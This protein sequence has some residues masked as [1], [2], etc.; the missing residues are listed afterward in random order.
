MSQINYEK[1]PTGG[2][3]QDLQQV[4]TVGNTALNDINLFGNPRYITIKPSSI[5]LSARLGGDI[6]GTGSLFLNNSLLQ[7]AADYLGTGLR[8][9]NSGFSKSGNLL[10]TPSNINPGENINW[11]FPYLN[12]NTATHIL[13]PYTDTNGNL[14]YKGF[15]INNG[16]VWGNLSFNGTQGQLELVSA[17]AVSTVVTSTASANRAI[18]L[19]DESGEIALKKFDE[20][21]VTLNQVGTNSPNKGDEITTKPAVTFTITRNST[22]IYEINLNATTTKLIPIVSCAQL[23][24]S[25]N[26]LTVTAKKT[27]A[28]RFLIYVQTILGVNTDDWNNSQLNVK[29]TV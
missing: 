18:T 8:F 4:L 1:L 16:S 14:N 13:A 29:Y 27:T 11:E 28:T 25:G 20:Y 21:S 26:N 6:Q 15:Y 24:S 12:G 23:T 5:I 10:F 17:G 3:S 9:S 22:G 2:G 19:P 7:Q